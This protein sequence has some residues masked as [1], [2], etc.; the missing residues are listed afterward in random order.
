MLLWLLLLLLPLPLL[1][2]HQADKEELVIEFAT[3]L[4]MTAGTVPF[5]LQCRIKAH[6]RIIWGVAWSPDSK[7]FATASRDG[8][9]KLWHCS[10][11]SNS[12]KPVATMS[13]GLPVT[14]I[15]FEA[16]HRLAVDSAASSHQYKLAMGLENGK[17]SVH[18]V[19]Q[20]DG[21]VSTTCLWESPME[22]SHCAP[23]RRIC[24]QAWE[25]DCSD[26][27]TD[28]QTRFATCAD[29]HCIRIFNIGCGSHNDGSAGHAQT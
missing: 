28:G 22:S 18:E 1:L 23:V 17:V 11:L 12:A 27:T 21:A 19:S 9:V 26:G 29:D 4:K 13:L 8:S 6:T 24:W 5:T 10:S 14:A 3:W 7:A 16:R 25:S 20:G 15:A 2:Q